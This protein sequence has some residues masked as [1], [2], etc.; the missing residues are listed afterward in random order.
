MRL[1]TGL[2][3]SSLALLNTFFTVYLEQV[4]KT[5]NI[6]LTLPYSEDIQVP[7]SPQG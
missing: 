2:S 3:A 4:F 7:P 5:I 6:L 1:L